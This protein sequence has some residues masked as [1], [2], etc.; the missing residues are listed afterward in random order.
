MNCRGLTYH[1]QRKTL[2]VVA[3]EGTLYEMHTDGRLARSE[4]LK[5]VDLEG[6]T[7]N[8]ET[9]LLYAV[10]EGEDNIVELAPGNFSD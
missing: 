5:Q 2:F 7:V 1:P 8:P 9:G 6:V 4:Q 10:I 3:D